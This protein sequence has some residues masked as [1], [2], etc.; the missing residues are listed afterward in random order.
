MPTANQQ[1]QS[2]QN[3]DKFQGSSAS[4]TETICILRIEPS[5]SART[6]CPLH[7]HSNSRQSLVYCILRTS[8]QN[9]WLSGQQRMI[10]CR[11]ISCPVAGARQTR[12]ES[13]HLTRNLTR[14]SPKPQGPLGTQ[15]SGSQGAGMSSVIDKLRANLGGTPEAGISVCHQTYKLHVLPGRASIALVA[16][17]SRYH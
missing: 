11:S 13:A 9:I 7:E 16:L 12:I 2:L 1:R 15:F 6:P 4:K 8:P 5:S 3:G 17:T 10:G 14:L